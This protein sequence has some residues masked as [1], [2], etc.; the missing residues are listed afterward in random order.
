MCQGDRAIIQATSS[1]KYR[2][3]QGGE[4]INAE[5][6][7][8][9]PISDPELPCN[10]EGCYAGMLIGRFVTDSGIETVFPI[11][12]QK[13]WEAPEHGTF[14]FQINDNSAWDNEWRSQGTITDHTA[15]TVSPADD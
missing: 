8:T 1:D 12:T 3:V 5:G 14:S 10:F 6:D 9:Q 13:I 7:L 2:I 15:V 4:Y 11:G